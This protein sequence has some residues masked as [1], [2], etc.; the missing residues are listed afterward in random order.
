MLNKIPSDQNVASWLEGIVG[1]AAWAKLRENT[2]TDMITAIKCYQSFNS[3]HETIDYASAI[4]AL[5]KAVEHELR[6]QFYDRYLDYL[7]SKYSPEDYVNIILPDSYRNNFEKASQL[8]NCVLKYNGYEDELSFVNPSEEEFFTFNSFKN[9]ISTSD[10]KGD[11]RNRNLDKTVIDYCQTVL[12]PN[13]EISNNAIRK[14][15][16][17]LLDSVEGQRRTRNNSAHGGVI[18]SK[19]DAEQAIKDV[20]TVGKLLAKIIYPPFLAKQQN[21]NSQK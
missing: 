13:I 15:L 18:Q 4:V 16:K 20:V 9:T 5:M 19:A 6:N 2:K 21:N 8:K 1:S 7:T 17:P 12:Y 10:L 11:R 3:I 14:W